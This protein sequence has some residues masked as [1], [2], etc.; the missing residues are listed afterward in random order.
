MSDERNDGDDAATKQS[1]RRLFTDTA[2]KIVNMVTSVADDHDDIHYLLNLIHVMLEHEEP[3][4]H[5]EDDS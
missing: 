3:C 1:R 2:S 4:D 5:R